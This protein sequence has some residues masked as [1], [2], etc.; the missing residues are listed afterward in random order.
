MWLVRWYRKQYLKC[1]W[2]QRVEL[3]TCNLILFCLR[4]RSS[5]LC[6]HTTV[7]DDEFSGKYS[8]LKLGSVT[9]DYTNI[10]GVTLWTE[11]ERLCEW[12][13]LCHG[14]WRRTSKAQTWYVHITPEI[15]RFYWSS[16]VPIQLTCMVSIEMFQI[17]MKTNYGRQ[18][19]IAFILYRTLQ[20]KPR[21]ILLLDVFKNNE[22][23]GTVSTFEAVIFGLKQF[24]MII[25]V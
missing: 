5:I 8:L 14:T 17:F 25:V 16:Q 4:A 11:Y 21:S 3:A 10:S 24:M 19:K 2:N 6:L 15:P 23:I 7:V 12:N 22:M 18:S 20:E 9:R 1:Y 13:D